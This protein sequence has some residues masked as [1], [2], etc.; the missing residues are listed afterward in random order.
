MSYFNS[1]GFGGR[2][3]TMG[4][5]DGMA[6]GGFG[7]GSSFN[8][9]YSMF[10]NAPIGQGQGSMQKGLQS[11]NI[12]DLGNG[13]YGTGHTGGNSSWGAFGGSR[14]SPMNIRS[15]GQLENAFGMNAGRMQ[16][17]SALMADYE[18]TVAAGRAHGTRVNDSLNRMN[19]AYTGGAANIRQ[20][21]QDAYADLT[22]RGDQFMSQGQE[23]VNQQTDFNKNVLAQSD[24]LMKEA[25]DNQTN[26]VA[27]D[28]S[29]MKFGMARSRGQ[30][31]NQLQSA[32]NMGDPSAQVALQNIDFETAQQ[33]QAAMSQ[34]SSQFN[35]A[36]SAMEMARAQNYG[37][38]GMQAGSNINAAGGIGASFASMAKG[39]YEQG[40]AIR[41][42]AEVVANQFYAQGQTALA[43]RIIANPGSPVSMA[44]VLSAMFAFDMTPGSETLTGMPGQ[45]LGSE[46]A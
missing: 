28:A 46:F 35:Q 34:I 18:N 42:G 12:R 16:F 27:S 38:V 31:R 1:G 14:S 26:Q 40:V 22:G 9:Y 4:P 39:M 21:G 44:S 3:G 24:N 43:D 15:Q 17:G 41:Q 5:G 45:F 6:P 37:Q 13:M 20:S 2:M 36:R 23:F 30:Q 32:A 10:A 11:G 7:Q 8:D 19:E 25:I 29:A 33:T